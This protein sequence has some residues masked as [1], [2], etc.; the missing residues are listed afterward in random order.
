VKIEEMKK[1]ILVVEDDSETAELF[2]EMLKLSGYQVRVCLNGEQAIKN[3]DHVQPD[4][5]VLDMMMPVSTGMDVLQHVRST[6]VF[7][8]VPVV[9]VSS[10]GMPGD[11]ENAVKA[12]TGSVG[13]D[14]EYSPVA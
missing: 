12:G 1:T 9:V 7:S 6:P 14:R 8:E 13:A 11:I 10:K 2:S 5:I 3:M 4:V